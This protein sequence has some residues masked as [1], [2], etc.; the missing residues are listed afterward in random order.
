[1]HHL[2]YRLFFEN[3]DRDLEV[4]CRPCHQQ[5]HEKS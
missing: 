3:V 4:L 2:N 1:V 5:V